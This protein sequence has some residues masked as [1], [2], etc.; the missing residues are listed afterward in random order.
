MLLALCYDF[1]DTLGLLRQHVFSA[2]AII[3]SATAIRE[4][5]VDSSIL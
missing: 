2:S 4:F 3:K 1:D 5:S